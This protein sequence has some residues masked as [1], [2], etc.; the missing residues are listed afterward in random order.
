[1]YRPTCRPRQPTVHMIRYNNNQNIQ[2]NYYSTLSYIQTFS[3]SGWK[4][5]SQDTVEYYVIH[6]SPPAS[7]IKKT[8]ASQ[9]YS[10]C[11]LPPPSVKQEKKTETKSESWTKYW[12][13]FFTFV[14]PSCRNLFC[15][16]TRYFHLFL[17][18]H[19]IEWF[20]RF[21]LVKKPFEETART[22]NL[23]KPIRRRHKSF[24]RQFILWNILL[25]GNKIL[26]LNLAITHRKS[27]KQV[28]QESRECNS[29]HRVATWRGYFVWNSGGIFHVNYIDYSLVSCRWLLTVAMICT[30]LRTF[31]QVKDKVCW[32]FENRLWC[33]Y[34][35]C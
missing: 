24:A 21:W 6:P 25:M 33:S 20:S 30:W 23:C 35:G 19:H 12:A 28:T 18:K 22:R 32:N 26:E 8:P 31:D 3:F 34:P 17:S 9:P 7:L 5:L 13:I 14:L 29:S 27:E 16:F 2:T 15:K 4:N 1:M 10:P 11:P